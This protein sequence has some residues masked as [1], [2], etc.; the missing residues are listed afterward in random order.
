MGKFAE[1]T[2][3]RIV[4][5]L[6]GDSRLSGETVLAA[7]TLTRISFFMLGASGVAGFIFMLAFFGS[8][9]L[10]LGL[11]LLI[12]YSAYILV[13]LYVKDGPR[14]LGL[15]GVLTK[16]KLILLGSSR[17]GIIKEWKLRELESLEMIRKGNLIVMGKLAIK[18]RKEDRMVFLVSN[19]GLGRYLVEKYEELH[20]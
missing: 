7:A 1:Q 18:P 20:G 19:Q 4:R 2:R 15:F 9:G 5:Q 12:G 11:G 3:E 14:V 17:V 13:L 8:G 10:Q 6:Q 16:R